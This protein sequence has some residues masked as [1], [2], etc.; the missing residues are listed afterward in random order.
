MAALKEADFTSV[1]GPFKFDNNQF[2]I[3]DWYM[4][5]VV[6][7]SKDGELRFAFRGK[8]FTAHRD[9][10]HDQCPMK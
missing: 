9:A 8:T 6:K 1:R 10:Y 5:E 7:D 3:T 2:P 4:W